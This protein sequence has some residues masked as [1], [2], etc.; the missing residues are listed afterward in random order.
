SL[1]REDIPGQHV[2][3][4]TGLKSRE[5]LRN[6]L[7]RHFS[8]FRAQAKRMALLLVNIDHLSWVNDRLGQ[9]RGDRLL[10]AAAGLVLDNIREG[11]IA[12]RFGGEEMLVVFGGDLNAGITLGER[13]RQAQERGLK[14]GDSMKDVLAIAEAEK[15]PCGTFSVGV[16]DATAIPDLA[17]ALDRVQQSLR[18]AKRSRNTVVC[19]D[20]ARAGQGLEPFS[21]FAEYRQARPAAVPPRRA[22]PGSAGPAGS[23]TPASPAFASQEKPG[24]TT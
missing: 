6:E 1:L 24:S 19:F 17:P 15:D 9:P 18:H 16:I 10:K 11:D 5:Y 2:D 8:E 14:H 20:P 23:V 22:G 4:L 12:I 13:L 21:S 3:G 7:P